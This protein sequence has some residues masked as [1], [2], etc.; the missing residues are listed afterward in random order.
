MEVA[1]GINDF[2]KHF[3]IYENLRDHCKLLRYWMY[4]LFWECIIVLLMKLSMIMVPSLPLWYE[5]RCVKRWIQSDWNAQFLDILFQLTSHAGSPFPGL[6]PE[7]SPHFFL[8]LYRC[9]NIQG[10][11]G[12]WWIPIHWK[13]RK[14]SLS[15]LAA[16][17]FLKHR[18]IV[19]SDALW[20]SY[21][22]LIFHCYGAIVEIYIP[23]NT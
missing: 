6:C 10:T 1:K 4:A 13:L 23:A 16:N 12:H 21:N 15:I 11:L 14:T 18:N 2:C 17:E 3:Y 20:I 19:K 7:H 22:K 9:R 8:F 5:M